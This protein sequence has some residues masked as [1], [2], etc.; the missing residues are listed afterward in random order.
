MFDVWAHE[1]M[2]K[3]PIFK[4]KFRCAAKKGE[5]EYFEKKYL[6]IPESDNGSGMHWIFARILDDLN[7]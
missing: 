1:E 4:K 2:K 6:M 3:G 5:T 7:T